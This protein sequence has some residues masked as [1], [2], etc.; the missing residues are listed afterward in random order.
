MNEVWDTEP[1]LWEMVDS[2]FY[3]FLKMTFI[4]LLFHLNH[5]QPLKAIFLW[6]YF[7]ALEDKDGLLIILAR[8]FR[9]FLSP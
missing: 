1:D 2:N 7:Y 6:L 4:L 3:F 5:M 8:K 9:K